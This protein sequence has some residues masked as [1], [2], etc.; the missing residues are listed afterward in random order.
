T[1]SAGAALDTATSA[2]AAGRT[3]RAAVIRNRTAA[4]SFGDQLGMFLLPLPLGQAWLITVLMGAVITL[5]AFGW[6]GWTGTLMTTV[7]AAAAFLPLATQG[8]SGDLAG[9]NVAVN[10]ILLH[11][12]GAAVWI[13]GLMLLVI[14]RGVGA[15][16][17]KSGKTDKA[18]AI[19]VPL[20]VSRYSTL[21]LAAF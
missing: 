19:D 1:A 9:H 7:L 18:D 14:L 21:A 8:H 20:L 13:G 6:R 5:L 12:V 4:S 17:A 11:T 2:I 3:R 15:K 10:A 16:S